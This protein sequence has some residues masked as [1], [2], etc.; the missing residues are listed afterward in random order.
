MVN[1]DLPCQVDLPPAA[2][3]L[4]TKTIGVD[5]SAARFLVDGVAEITGADQF[6][7]ANTREWTA[8]Q[9]VAQGDGTTLEINAKFDLESKATYFRKKVS[10]Q[11]GNRVSEVECYVGLQLTP[12]AP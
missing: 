11:N 6:S 8:S 3:V 5:R 4:E 9:T 1:T 2:A 12:R 10:A 7:W